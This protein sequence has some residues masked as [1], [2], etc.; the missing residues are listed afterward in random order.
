MSHLIKQ[1]SV[2]L[3]D[4]YTLYLKTQNYHWHV[5]GAQFSSLHN[6]FEKQYRELAEAVDA[7]AERMII[8]GHP[9]P[10]TFK[11]FESLRTL[12]EGDAS[13]NANQMLTDLV[14]DH[15]A[16][17]AQLQQALLSAQEQH[18]EGSVTLVDERI[19]AHEKMRWML[20]ASKE[21]N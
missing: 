16:L 10:A 4:T 3:A 12:K 9:A 2:V 1:L 13:L 17:L 7:L 14:N 21:E 20:N 19:T 6:L 11:A 15:T 5:K 8:K 18:D